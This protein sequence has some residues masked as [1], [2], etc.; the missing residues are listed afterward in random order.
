MGIMRFSV[1]CD[2]LMRR[3][4]IRIKC[5]EKS[6]LSAALLAATEIITHSKQFDLVEYHDYV[7]TPEERPTKQFPWQVC[8]TLLYK[9]EKDKSNFLNFLYEWLKNITNS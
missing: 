6:S 4:I 1:E 2:K 5:S 7:R 8:F 9:Y 3:I